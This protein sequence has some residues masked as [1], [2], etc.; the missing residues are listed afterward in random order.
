[1]CFFYY[2]LFSRNGLC[3]VCTVCTLQLDYYYY[4]LHPWNMV[5]AGRSQQK[6]FEIFVGNKFR[7]FFVVQASYIV[8]TENHTLFTHFNCVVHC[9]IFTVYTCSHFSI[10]IRTFLSLC[11]PKMPSVG[12]SFFPLTQNLFHFAV[13]N[14]VFTVHAN[15]CKVNSNTIFLARYKKREQKKQRAESRLLILWK[16]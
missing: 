9:V 15:N 11:Q 12:S 2:F 8:K 6:I 3:L 5:V 10:V 4:C 14:N 13:A 16:F 1:M 7:W